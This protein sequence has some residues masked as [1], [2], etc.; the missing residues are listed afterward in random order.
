MMEQERESLRAMRE[1]DEAMITELVE[2]MKEK[3]VEVVDGI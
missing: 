2:Y 1:K 3:K